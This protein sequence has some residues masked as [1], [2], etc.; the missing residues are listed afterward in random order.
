MLWGW[1][2]LLVIY[3][4]V[5]SPRWQESNI[6]IPRTESVSGQF[7]QGGLGTVELWDSVSHNVHTPPQLLVDHLTLDQVSFMNKN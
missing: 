1:H 4:C 6:V 2:D 7:G 5:N 3:C